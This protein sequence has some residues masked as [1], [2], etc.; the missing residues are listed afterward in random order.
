[1]SSPNIAAIDP[2]SLPRP[3]D[4]RQVE[5]HLEQLMQILP[6]SQHAIV[7]TPVAQALLKALFGNSPFLSRCLLAEA[8][9]FLALLTQD[10]D[11]VFN[12]VV[13]AVT[14][15]ALEN[16]DEAGLMQA[17]RRARR[18]V[19]LI[20]AVADISAHWP[21]EKVTAA[22][23]QFADVALQSSIC[24]LLRNLASAGEIDLPFPDEPERECGLIVL[25]LGKLGAREL[26]YSSDIDL[27]L[28]FEREKVRYKGRKTA[29]ECF[30]RLARNL[31]RL[32][33]DATADG[34]VFRID[35]RLRPDPASTPLVI[36]T[37]AAETYYEGMGQNWERA[38]MIKARVVAGDIVAGDLYLYRLRPFIWRK[39]LDFAAIQDIHS[40]KRQIYA[41]KGHRQVAVAGHN[42]K[43]GRGG[44]REVEFFAQTQ[45]LIW[46]RRAKELRKRATCPAIEGL[47]AFGKCQRQVADELIAA[48]RYLRQVEHRL[49]MIDDQQT[50]TLPDYG[51]ALDRVALFCGHAGTAEFEAALR[52]H[53]GRVEDHYAELFEEAPTLAGADAGVAGSLVFTGTEDDPETVSTLERMGFPSGSAVA[54]QIRA[55][56]HGRYRATRSARA[57]ELL[58]ELMPRL[59][60]TLGRT[61]DPETAF[62]RFD[63]FLRALPAGVQ[64]FAL[65]YSNP[66]LLDLIAEVMGTAPLLAEQLARRPA[67]LDGVL[68]AGLYDANA[69]RDT[70][71]ADLERQLDLAGDFQDALDILR[72]WTKDQQFQIG[73]RIL[74]GTL[75]GDAAGPLL[76]D[77]ADCALAALFPRVEA[78]FQIQHG[79]LPG[80]GMVFLALGKLGSREM[81]MTSD[82]DLVFVYDIP[83]DIENW[84]TT[85]SSGA[86]PL[87][88][89]QYYARLAQ[90][91][92][93]AITAQTEEGRLFEVDM[94]L[95]PSGNSGP[96]ASGLA[97]FEKY[98]LTEAW[99]WEHMA[100]TRARAIAGDASLADDTMA[101][102]GR[103]I[104]QRRDLEKLRTDILDMR[105]RMG[106]QYR[107]DDMW[108]LKHARG[109]QVDIDFISQYLILKHAVDF[110]SIVAGDPVIALGE[111]HLLGLIEP[112]IG[113]RLI[114]A[115]RFWHRL[116][117]VTRLIVGSKLDEEKLGV[118]AKKHLAQ[119]VNEPDFGT[120]KAL[121]L[122]QQALV[123]DIFK[124]IFDCDR[125]DEEI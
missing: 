82:L 108:D 30:V 59:L 7:T 120:L 10:I 56:H 31:V 78:E 53:L 79:K 36:S 41:V 39:H 29:Q 21:L 84:D 107:T 51:P 72:R 98:Q 26:N 35:L 23:S 9:T 85:L 71:S 3:S 88:P 102:I 49:Q 77:V 60:G 96:I 12:N 66:A 5:L 121:I 18:R 100:L 69:D 75:D 67:L 91:V 89:I 14:P 92:I 20:V 25:G 6:Q 94:R 63:D 122:E 52:Y 68:A 34:Y 28:L 74:R 101:M 124:T 44:I 42:I 86:K 24:H 87:A 1:M 11:S 105:R 17:L 46:G 2:A 38:A 106:M 19:A 118:P 123:F 83:P 8:D 97:P 27:I 125:T 64:V 116:Q 104:C 15:K 48:Y 111:A 119:I 65:L 62:R 37:L 33:Q 103:V 13:I 50:Q 22:L 114:E 113:D 115:G 95:R 76:A 54:T 40:I 109:G 57:R 110:P 73:V 4:P 47:V 80:R 45:Q 112:V 16:L 32:L 117:Q 93:S 90:R 81:T 55:W 43:L 70:L 99:T 61:A 58:T